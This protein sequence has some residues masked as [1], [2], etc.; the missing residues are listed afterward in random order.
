M[1]IGLAAV[2]YAHNWTVAQA[3]PP[4]QV[5]M[6]QAR[7]GIDP[8]PNVPVSFGWI[9]AW[10]DNL[11]FQVG[12]ASYHGHIEAFECL[13]SQSGHV[14]SYNRFG[15]VIPTAGSLPVMINYVGG[16][17]DAWYQIA[18]RWQFAGRELLPFRPGQVKFE[19]STEVYKGQPIPLVLAKQSLPLSSPEVRY[20]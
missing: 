1:I 14:Y 2:I 12:W 7:V 17:W 6:M 5:T 18:G 16:G 13:I 10:G 19:A 3:R 11:L 8:N 15:P 4:A 9:G 20:L